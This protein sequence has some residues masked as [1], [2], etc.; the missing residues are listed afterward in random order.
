MKKILSYV[1][2]AVVSS[3][4]TVIICDSVIESRIN[5]SYKDYIEA[6]DLLLH[7]VEHM[8]LYHDIHWGDTVCEGDTWCNFLDARFALGLGDFTFEY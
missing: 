7:E 4:I 1:I 2:T 8:C 6:S 3:V 5:E